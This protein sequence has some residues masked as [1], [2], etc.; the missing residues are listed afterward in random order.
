MRAL[1]QHGECAASDPLK[2]LARILILS[3]WLWGLPPLPGATVEPSIPQGVYT[4]RTNFRYHIRVLGP[5]TAKAAGHQLQTRK[6]RENLPKPV[7]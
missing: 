5:T 4:C 2:T 6:G 7:P 3:A 1:K